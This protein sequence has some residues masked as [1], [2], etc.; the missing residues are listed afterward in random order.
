M[1]FLGNLSD[2]LPK[3]AVTNIVSMG[4]SNEYDLMGIINITDNSFVKDSRMLSRGVDAVLQKAQWMLDQG[5]SYIDVGACS[6][7]PGNEFI[8]AE[9]EWKRLEEPLKALFAAFGGSG[10]RFSVDTFRSSIVEKCLESGCEIIVNDIF[11]GE[12]DARIL[13]VTAANSLTY[14]AMDQTS[15]P[16]SYFVKWADIAQKKGIEDWILDPGFGFGKTVEQNWEILRCLER[17][18]DFGRPVLSA[19]SR[20]RMIYLPLGLD[21]MTCSEQSV[22]AER[23]AASKGASIIRTH[24]ADKHRAL[25]SR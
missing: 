5:V 1:A 23:L 8:S 22:E 16:Y 10:V 15:D 4:Q 2:F 19:T 17:F 7:A 3:F 14:I 13:D 25:M 11:A 12:A 21:P 6:S 9:Q 24:D 18:L 20:K